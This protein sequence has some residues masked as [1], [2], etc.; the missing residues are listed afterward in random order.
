MV[1]AEDAHDKLGERLLR[2]GL[3]SD[4]GALAL[5][6]EHQ[7]EPIG[8][9]ALWLTDREHRQAEIGWVLDPTYGG[10]G[11]AGEAV[12]AT[13]ALGFEHYR[14]H[15]VTAQMDAR[16]QASAALA[17]RVGMRL[18]AH[19]VQDWFSKGDWTDTLVFARLAAEHQVLGNGG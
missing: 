13:L 15:R 16:N 11:L 1:D 8:D 3:E 18:E 4:S 19:H 17:R 2:T 5:V 9:V 10:R 14:L 6:I 7:G 12:Q